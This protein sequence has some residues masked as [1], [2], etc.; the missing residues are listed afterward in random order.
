[1]THSPLIRTTASDWKFKHTGYTRISEILN[2]LDTLPNL[3]SHYLG[4]VNP[5]SKPYQPA[6]KA[7]SR[8]ESAPDWKEEL[9]WQEGQGRC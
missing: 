6:E 7:R 9:Q 4:T 5:A 1:M 8:R 2:Q 3:T